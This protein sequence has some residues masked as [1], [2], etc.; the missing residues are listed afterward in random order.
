[1]NDIDYCN[2]QK[3]FFFKFNKVYNYLLSSRV[4]TPYMYF[5]IIN[6]Y[7]LNQKIIKNNNIEWQRVRESIYHKICFHILCMC[8]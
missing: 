3:I 2:T 1:M 6:I 4:H 7:K 8:F 5:Y